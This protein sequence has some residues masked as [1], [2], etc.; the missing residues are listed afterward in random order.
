[1]DEVK[2]FIGL[3]KVRSIADYQFGKGVGTKLFPDAVKLSFSSKTGRVRHIY[4]DDKLL[5]TLRPN[6]GLLA[7]SIEG[8]KRLQRILPPPK[9]RV[10][11]DA[12]Y[13]SYVVKGKDVQTRWVKL[14]DPDIRPGDEVLVVNAHDELLAIGKAVLPGEWI[15][16]FKAGLAIKVRRGVGA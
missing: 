7:L 11:I 4:L 8:A 10:V 1:M 9:M 6:D 2:E 5:A 14:A 12:K 3:R 15:T 16:T 13:E